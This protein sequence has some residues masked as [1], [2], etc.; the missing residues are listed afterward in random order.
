MHAYLLTTVCLMNIHVG[1]INDWMLGS[2]IMKRL[3]SIQS[4]MDLQIHTGSG[5]AKALR[6]IQISTAVPD[7]TW[8]P[9]QV[10]QY[11]TVL[12]KC[13]CWQL[14]DAVG[15]SLATDDVHV[16]HMWLGLS[17]CI[18]CTCSHKRQRCKMGF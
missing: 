10:E 2:R 9:W 12:H 17:T 1:F 15:L 4:F 11:H 3:P 8:I 16:S 14:S 18:Y 7:P 6:L 13:M 5:D